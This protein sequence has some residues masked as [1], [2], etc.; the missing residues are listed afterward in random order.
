MTT[1]SVERSL[2]DFRGAAD[3]LV[4]VRKLGFFGIRTPQVDR[5]VAYYAEALGLAITE[6]SGDSC[7][8]STGSDHHVVSISHGDALSP[9][10]IGFEISESL[11]DAQTRLTAGGIATERLS[12]P[13]PGIASCLKLTDPDGVQLVL[14]EAQ[15]SSGDG[16]IPGIRPTKLG[17]IALHVADLPTAQIFYEDVLGFRW[18]DT[19][20]DFFTFMRCSPNHHSINLLA[21]PDANGA[22]GRVHHVAY[23]TRDI[24]HLKDA[25]D[26][27]SKFGHLLEWGL[28]RHGA[29]HNL[30]SYHR[31]P[32]GNLV[33]LFAELDI[34]NDE[35]TGYFEPRPW[36]D[37]YPQGPRVWDPG[38]ESSNIWG[39]MPPW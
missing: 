18:S 34:V 25:L 10:V 24:T 37:S 30:F 8:L 4:R 22:F 31:D 1:T 5:M 17:H 2:T 33:E 13:E 35:R 28:G 15:A 36:H 29:G 3:P 38:H 27:I 12:D 21:R 19:V 7:Y 23:E 14:Y 16:S 26:H 32:D 11:E 20:G 39:P 6:R 9:S